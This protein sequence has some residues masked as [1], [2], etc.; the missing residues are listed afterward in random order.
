MGIRITDCASGF[1]AIRFSKL[2]HVDLIQD[3]YHTTELII[4]AAKKKLRF[5]DRP[6]HI[7]ARMH[8]ESKKGRNFTY[9]F[10]FFK[11]VIQTWWR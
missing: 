1:R 2:G 10:G 4:D 8:G 6:I 5:A 7:H 9:A 11:T 3:Q